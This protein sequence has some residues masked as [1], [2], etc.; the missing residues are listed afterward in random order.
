MF[1]FLGAVGTLLVPFAVFLTPAAPESAPPVVEIWLGSVIIAT[2]VFFAFL[3]A[4]WLG[5][6]F[7]PTALF[8]ACSLVRCVII[9]EIRLG[10]T[11]TEQV[12]VLCGCII[13]IGASTAGA[14]VS[15]RRHRS[16]AAA[17]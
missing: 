3:A 9:P 10:L 4:W 15:V 13:L 12:S 6:A 16:I 5:L 17:A 2:L 14:A 7:L 1:A 8:I 11:L